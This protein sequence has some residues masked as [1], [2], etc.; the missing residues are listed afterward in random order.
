MR[1]QLFGSAKPDGPTIAIKGV[2]GGFLMGLANLVPGISGGTMLLAVGIYPQVIRSIAEVTTF[3]FSSRSLTLLATVIAG[4]AIAIVAGAGLLKNLVLE[5]RWIMYSLFIGLTL[6]GVP[7]LWRMIKP[8]NATALI[9]AA[10][11]LAV[12]IA[13]VIAQS[14]EAGHSG[15]GG[16][17]QYAM[18]FLAGVAGA[19]AM[20]LPGVS[21]AYIFL[22]L[23]QYLII[24]GAIENVPRA[25]RTLDWTGLIDAMGVI[26][27]VGLGAVV[28]LV[29]VSNLIKLL[30]DRF[31]KATLGV[32]LGLL[33]GAVV[34][35]WPFQRPVVPVG[36]LA[37][38]AVEAA[39][40]FAPSAAEVAVS[41]GLIVAGFAASTAVSHLGRNTDA[42]SR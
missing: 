9:G 30:L 12:M 26:I 39:E 40:F 21:G 34:G 13:L 16:D 7:I 38:G 22:A 23:G 15:P 11:G 27:P 37:V 14:G 42:R 18:L 20:I 3:K 28:G 24:L 5:H 31:E 17:R 4:M 25:A 29:A 1:R 35:L 41:L 33:L 6:G 10:V 8:P 36:D 32:L 19:S 2:L